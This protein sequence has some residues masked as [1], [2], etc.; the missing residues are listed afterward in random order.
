VDEGGCRR[1]RRVDQVDIRI[2]L[3]LGQALQPGD[4][5]RDAHAAADPDLAAPFALE[6]EAAV[7]PFHDDG[8][9]GEKL[10]RQDAGI[11]AQS[12]DAEAQPAVAAPYGGHGEGMRAL[13]AAEVD[14]G[15]LSRLMAG[16]GRAQPDADIEHRVVVV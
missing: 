7:W 16:P 13:A 3:P 14:E 11:V 2:E 10:L 1:P 6:V 5:R 12:L 8:L 9:A 4:E 15:E